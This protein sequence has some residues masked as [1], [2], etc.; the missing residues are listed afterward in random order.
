MAIGIQSQL[1]LPV[2]TLGDDNIAWVHSIKYLGITLLGGK[3][4]MFDGSIAKQSFFS[5]CNY[6]YAHAKQLDELVHL[7]LQES[8]CLPVLTYTVAA[9]KYNSMQMDKP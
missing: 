8:H 4:L 6:I 3:A 1:N 9:I 2:M 5:G 7:S